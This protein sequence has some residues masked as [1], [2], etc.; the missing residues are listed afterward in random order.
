MLG[1]MSVP[2]S[3]KKLLVGQSRIDFRAAEAFIGDLYA[4]AGLEVPEEFDPVNE[5]IKVVTILREQ[6]KHE[7]N[8]E[9]T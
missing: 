2:P 6:G 5:I 7:K 9:M 8:L 1:M 4:N 3:A